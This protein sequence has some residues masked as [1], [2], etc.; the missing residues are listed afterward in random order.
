MTNPNAIQRDVSG[1][2]RR[3]QLGVDGNA[4]FS[5]RGDDLVVGEAEFVTVEQIGDEPL[6]VAERRA[7]KKAH[8]NL[9]QRLGRTI[10]FYFGPSHPYGD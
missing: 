5:L 3:A 10:P 9:E 2:E 1:E 4:G 8:R 6:S 7:A